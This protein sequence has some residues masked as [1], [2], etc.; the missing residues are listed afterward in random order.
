MLPT[1]LNTNEV[2]DS[3]GTEVEFGR[4]STSDRKLVFA[5]VGEAPNLIHRIT[6][7][8]GESGTGLNRIRRSNLSTDLQV[9]G[10]D[11]NPVAIK[12]STTYQIPVGN[13]AAYTAVTTAAANHNSLLTS[14]GASTTILFDG[15]GYGTEALINGSL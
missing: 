3:A 11:G 4:L 2:K 10:D 15:T 14:R 13:L 12:I 7:Q 8:H 1:T 6:I 9:D 5:K